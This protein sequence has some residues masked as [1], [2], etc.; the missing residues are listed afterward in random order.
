MTKTV[1]MALL[2]IAV[3]VP[4]ATDFVLA[5]RGI[6][7]A[8][9]IVP[10]DAAP[11]T[12]TAAGTLAD[13][14]EKITGAKPKLLEGE[15][16]PVP[17]RAIWV[18]YQPA[19]EKL[20]PKLD[21]DFKHPEEILLAA[22]G[23]HV[24]IAGRD[25]WDAQRP[26]VLTNDGKPVPKQWEYGTANAVYTFLQDKLD[27]RWLWPGELGED[28]V[29]R[30]TIRIAPFVYRYHPTIRSRDGVFH[31]SGLL[32][33]RGYGQSHDW[34]RFQRLQLDSLDMEGGHAFST[35][36]E[37][38]HQTHPD[39]FALQPDGTRSGWPSP[40][41]AKLC[42]SNPKVGQLWL[43]EV[44]EQLAKDPYRRVFNVSP[45]DGWM[46]GF[47]VC[48]RCRAW[49]HP[50]GE[51]RLFIWKGHREERPA[52]TDRQITF[53]NRLAQLLKERY[54][55]KDY[56]VLLFAYGHSRPAPVKARPADNVIIGSVANFFGRTHLVDRGSTRGET[57]LQQFQAWAKIAP[58]LM[59][60]PN[61]G[62]PAGWQQG[63]PDLS[64][65]QTIADLKLVAASRCIGIFI[66]AVWEHWATQGPQY[67]VMAQLVWNP[68]QDG[69]A[70]LKDYYQRG[71]GP[72][73]ADV[74]AYYQLLE[75]ARMAYVDKY[76][77]EAPVLTL[78]R[79]YTPEL[80]QQ[81]A[82][83]L[84]KA[85]EKVAAAPLYRQR[86]QFV[87]AGLTWTQLMTENIRLM[88]SYWQKKDE[89][90]AAKVQANWEKM[91][92]HCQQHPYAINWGPCRPGTKRMLG[93]DPQHPNPKVNRKRLQELDLN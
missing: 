92:R 6:A 50:D 22:G 5:D 36:W 79:L 72:A 42:D 43:K 75:R 60:R 86:V 18:G 70:L 12:K 2:M 7:P 85:E 13:Y 4:A 31:Y 37:R 66:D 26:T 21:F 76:G 20:F 24:V 25:R 90:T 33:K 61:T 73:A 19:V 27:V 45:N 82:E 14:V 64:I 30:Q 65:T 93:L 52:L 71:F 23:N 63:L 10:Q 91:E 58:H 53:A 44:E 41:T 57:H 54:P 49:D 35:W 77:Y 89:A 88:S 78:S 40:R 34:T 74:E 15:P 68:T 29:K 48:E 55:G 11:Y 69:A 16:Q 87:H 38:Y 9:I 47:C 1:L 83:C 81:A 62:S 51:P 67:Y 39:I 17:A 8:P 80:L 3:T 56:Y 84:R 32:K 46:S 59:W 28:I